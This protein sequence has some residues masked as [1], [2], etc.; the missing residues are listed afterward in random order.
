MYIVLEDGARHYSNE[1]NFKKKKLFEMGL[2]RFSNIRFK[3]EMLTIRFSDGSEGYT[4]LKG[5]D[6]L[7]QLDFKI[8]LK[9][10]FSGR[11]EEH[12][13]IKVNG[14][15]IS[16]DMDVPSSGVVEVIDLVCHGSI[17]VRCNIQGAQFEFDL[18]IDPDMVIDDLRDLLKET[19]VQMTL[20]KLAPQFGI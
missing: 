1:L 5:L 16:V 3:F 13:S 12:F 19:F 11:V 10:R 17:K 6:S 2:N 9:T 7:E 14:E 20:S 8:V 4:S 15:F 18:N